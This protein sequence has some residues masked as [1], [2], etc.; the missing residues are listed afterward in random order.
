[1]AY[2]WLMVD[3]DYSLQ[4]CFSKPGS[5]PDKSFRAYCIRIRINRAEP[6]AWPRIFHIAQED[7][8]WFGSMWIDWDTDRGIKALQNTLNC[9]R[10]SHWE[11]DEVFVMRDHSYSAARVFSNFDCGTL[12]CSLTR[13]S[14]NSTLLLET[15]DFPPCG[16]KCKFSTAVS[17]DD[18][19]T[20]I[21][22]DNGTGVMTASWA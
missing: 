2:V 21:C 7:L 17:S 22:D 1:M 18:Q 3:V 12:A 11:R 6:F 5:P 16:A 20:C 8:L 14:S 15:A 19:P 4:T 9:R 13:V 10:W